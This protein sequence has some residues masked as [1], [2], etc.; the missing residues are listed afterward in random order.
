M[1]QIITVLVF[2]IS[3]IAFSQNSK[4]AEELLNEV[5]NTAQSYENIS[6]DFKYV[7]ENVSEDIKQETR[8]NVIMK[9]DKYRLNILGI[10][11]LFDGKK[12]YTISPEDEEV[13]VSSDNSEDEN[14]MTLSKMMSFY[15]EGYNYEMDILQDVKDRK[16][17]FVKLNP[18]D[19]NAEVKDIFL[20]IDINTKHIYKL[21]E[22]GANGTKTTLTVNSFKTNEPISK[23]LFTFDQN[24]Y[25]EY[26]INNLD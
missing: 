23:T 2:L 13:T 8:G 15:K 10:T 24:K 26:Y 9:G 4:P 5:Y 22:I 14:N 18:I 11:R 17:Q 25:K 7:L 16:I 20:G 3:T 6:V 19:T 12:M 21:I 1:K